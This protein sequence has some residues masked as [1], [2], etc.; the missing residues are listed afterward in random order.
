IL[1]TGDV[2]SEG[3]NLHTQCNDLVHYDIPWSLI[4][5]EQRNGRIDRYGQKHRP[6]IATLL[7]T[8]S[9]S[10]FGGDLRV[11]ARLVDREHEAH[12]ALGDSASLMGTYDVKGEE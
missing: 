3:V 4:R 8:P 10:H 9:T 7:L 2:A 12:T 11:L 6:Q 1:V 5:I